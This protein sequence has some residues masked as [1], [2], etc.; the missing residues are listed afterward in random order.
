MIVDSE[1]TKINLMQLS[2]QTN[3]KEYMWQRINI[4]RNLLGIGS[5]VMDNQRRLLGHHAFRKR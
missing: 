1:G 3:I 2:E 4:R 5:I